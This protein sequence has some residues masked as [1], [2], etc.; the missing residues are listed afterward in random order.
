MDK[1][2]VNSQS[3]LYEQTALLQPLV[4]PGVPD[5]MF[6][7]QPVSQLSCPRIASF[8]ASDCRMLR[9]ARMLIVE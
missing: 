3:W 1:E 4:L 5:L 2:V 8:S 9:L 7:H 6:S